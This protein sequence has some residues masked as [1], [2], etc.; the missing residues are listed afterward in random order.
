MASIANRKP[1]TR[2][3][4][5]RSTS[6]WL[7]QHAFS[8][9][10]TLANFRANRSA[11]LLNVLVIG[12]TLALPLGLQVLHKNFL[13][14]VGHLGSHPQATLFLD[15]SYSRD[16]AVALRESLA[17]DPRLG[18]IKLIDRDQALGEF[19]ESSGLENILEMLPTNPLPHTLAIEIDMAHFVRHEADSLEAELSDMAGVSA[20]KFD[21]TW[22]RRL[23]AVSDVMSRLAIIFATLLGAGVV[24][25]TGN[26]IRVGIHSR[27]DEIEVV[28][29]CGATD[30]FVRRPFLYSGAIQGFSGAVVA[31]IVV[32]CA[33]S[34][35]AGPLDQLTKLY[36]T[37]MQLS[38]ISGISFLMV[39]LAGALLGWL[40]AWIS[41]SVYLRELDAGGSP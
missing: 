3:R 18:E 2:H 37:T 14:L 24:L 10:D 23:Q 16:Q 26:T 25:I 38:N 9:K 28:K 34:L 21:V 17:E 40:G 12:I 19:S 6:A 22:V 15:Q 29:L 27:R 5:P 41:V 33:F 1:A 4:A 36:E 8:V 30:A 39:L 20:A 7:R 35:L 13:V 32:A 31:S 11:V